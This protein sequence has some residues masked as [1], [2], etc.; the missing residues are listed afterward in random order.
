MQVNTAARITV[1]GG[2][3]PP[4][5]LIEAP[6]RGDAFRS[7]LVTP[8]SL[9]GA[10]RYLRST[11]LE[12]EQDPLAD[13]E[14]IAELR[15]TGLFVEADEVPATVR[16][17][18]TS[19]AD[20]PGPGPLRQ[21]SE[22]P[23]PVPGDWQEPD[24]G[25]VRCPQSRLWMPVR[26]ASGGIPGTPE[27]PDSTDGTRFASAWPQDSLA[28]VA[29]ATEAYTELE[30]L[31]P[32]SAVQALASYYRELGNQGYLER[33]ESRGVRRLIAHNHSAAKFW[34]YQ[35]N[36][37]VSQLVGKRTKPSYSFVS[38]YLQGSDL[39]WHTDR[40]PCEYTITLLIEYAPLSSDGRSAWPLLIRRRDGEVTAVHQR[41]GDALIFKGR[42]LSHS[43]EHLP[44]GH[45]SLSLLFHYV[46]AEYEGELD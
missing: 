40:P 17:P 33:R 12:G 3:E 22:L 19:A 31:L 42:E 11:L 44:D 16:Y 6:C 13:A 25:F 21:A 8:E 1:Q 38:S 37:R 10:Y 45:Q 7:T 39:F 28:R 34:H 9:P 23:W 30:H 27:L 36:E 24:T 32:A 5:F 18:I 41:V 35:L 29:F 2:D 4:S 46:D 43:R 15:R 14:V 26:A 20:L